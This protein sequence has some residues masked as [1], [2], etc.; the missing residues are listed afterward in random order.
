[1]R[2]IYI[3]IAVLFIFSACREESIPSNLEESNSFYPLQIG[4]TWIY[5][6]DSTLYLQGGISRDTSTTFVKEQ[7]TEQLQSNLTEDYVLTRSLRKS[8]NDPWQVTDIWTVS[9]NGNRITKTEENL[10][11]VKLQ[12]PV[13]EGSTW[14]PYALFDNMIDVTIGGEI[15]TPYT[16]NEAIVNTTGSRIVEGVSYDEVVSIAVGS[17]FNNS[18][19]FRDRNEWYAKDVGLIYKNEVVLDCRSSDCDSSLPWLDRAKQGYTMEM[20]LLSYSN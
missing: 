12:A 7:I 6:V 17:E 10:E 4:N 5:A 1:M 14:A 16:N 2:L 20:R 15:M 9:R 18:I 19:S 8:E 3:G 11:F 13:Q